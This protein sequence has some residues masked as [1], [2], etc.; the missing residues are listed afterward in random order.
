MGGKSKTEDMKLGLIIPG[1]KHQTKVITF[2]I[3]E[4]KKE[5]PSPCKYDG[6]NLSLNRVTDLGGQ[7]GDVEESR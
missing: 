4:K 5:L 3:I 7:P 6:H 1:L 2:S